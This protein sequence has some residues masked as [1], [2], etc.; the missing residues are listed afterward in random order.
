MTRTWHKEANISCSVYIQVPWGKRGSLFGKRWLNISKTPQPTK[1]LVADIF[2]SGNHRCTTENSFANRLVTDTPT[3]IHPNHGPETKI[4]EHLCLRLAEVTRTSLIRTVVSFVALQSELTQLPR[5]VN[6]STSSSVT[7]FILVDDV[8]RNTI[9]ISCV[10]GIRLSLILSI[11]DGV[12]VRFLGFGNPQLHVIFPHSNS[13]IE[14]AA[15]WSAQERH[16]RR[17]RIN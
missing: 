15:F 2:L 1:L 17:Q 10:A 16:D 3:P 9:F 8:P 4:V 6:R 12:R 11:Q 14:N 13:L 5:Y 7:L